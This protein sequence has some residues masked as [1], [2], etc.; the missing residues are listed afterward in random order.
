MG[1]HNF[2]GNTVKFDSGIDADDGV[3]KG[4]LD[5]AIAGAKNLGNATGT[6]DVT[7]RVADGSIGVVK[8]S[9]F[10]S[11][12]NSLATA[13]ANARVAQL[14]VN[15]DPDFDTF[16]ELSDKLGMNSSLIT[17]IGTKNDQ[18][19]ARIQALENATAPSTVPA[20]VAVPATAAN[21]PISFA[22]GKGN[23]EVIAQAW[24]VSGN[25]IAYLLLSQD[26]TNGT[27]IVDPGSIAIA[28]NTYYVMVL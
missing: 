11:E 27:L 23:R 14:L 22:H 6:L 9:N 17:A 16:K 24:S 8:I 10:T 4:Q 20:K 28:S 19:D 3:T 21:T 13:A 15:A 25:K 7:Q 2:R 18:Q 12:V 26:P 1:F 5:T